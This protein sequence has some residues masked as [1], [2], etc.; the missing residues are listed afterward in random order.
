M[1]SV[2]MTLYTEIETKWIQFCMYLQ[3]ILR[4]YSWD[5]LKEKGVVIILEDI[6]CTYLL[7]SFVCIYLLRREII[8]IRVFT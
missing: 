3:V 8:G 4:G 1:L 6:Q 2:S 5:Q 7:D